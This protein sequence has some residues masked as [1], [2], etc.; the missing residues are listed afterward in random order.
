MLLNMMFIKVAPE[1]SADLYKGKSVTASFIFRFLQ[2]KTKTDQYSFFPRNRNGYE[3][4]KK[5]VDPDFRYLLT[6][7]RM[8][9][10]MALTLSDSTF[11]PFNLTRYAERL[12]Y[13]AHKFDEDHM[14]ILKPHNISLGK[15]RN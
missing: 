1:L 2:A 4:M 6:V 9:T 12:A 5:Y 11:I 15:S 13:Y 8:W 3:W 7:G 14:A 10:K